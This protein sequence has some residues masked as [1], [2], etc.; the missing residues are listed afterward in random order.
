MNADIAVSELVNLYWKS[1]V[2]SPFIKARVNQKMQVR[3]VDNGAEL[4][5]MSS[6]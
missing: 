6:W 1:K 2:V 5:T 3:G 4:T